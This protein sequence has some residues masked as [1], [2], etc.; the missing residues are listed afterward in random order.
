MTDIN[1]SI[2]K[3]KAKVDEIGVQ[4]MSR[5]SGVPY[6]TIRS[7]ITRDFKPQTVTTLEQLEKVAQENSA[8]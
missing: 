6:T 3:I 7:L 2:E 1:A 4:E 8:A 5:R